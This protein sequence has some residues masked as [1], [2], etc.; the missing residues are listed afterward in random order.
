MLPNPI[1]V[2]DNQLHCHLRLLSQFAKLVLLSMPSS[3]L[4]SQDSIGTLVALCQRLANMVI[5]LCTQ[6]SFISSP[7]IG[8]PLTTSRF[9]L[10]TD[11]QCLNELVRVLAHSGTQN[12]TTIFGKTDADPTAPYV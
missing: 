7:S 12:Q 8:V 1:E 9:T 4:L 6:D 5:H 10:T 2:A 11:S 3:C